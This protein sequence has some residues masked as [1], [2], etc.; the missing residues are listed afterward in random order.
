MTKRIS[1]IS[2]MATAQFLVDAVLA[3]D[4]S[5]G[6]DVHFESVGG[7]DAARRITLS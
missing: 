1:G 5:N 2:S 3:W 4:Q 7:V 6:I